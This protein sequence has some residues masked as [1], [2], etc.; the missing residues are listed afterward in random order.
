MEFKVF[1]SKILPKYIN[2][3]KI[4]QKYIRNT[5]LIVLIYFCH[6]FNWFWKEIPQIHQK[7][8]TNI[9]LLPHCQFCLQA[10]NTDIHVKL[11][12]VGEQKLYSWTSLKMTNN[13]GTQTHEINDSGGNSK[14]WIL[15]L[16]G[17]KWK[18]HE[19]KCSIWDINIL[20]SIFRQFAL[21]D[22]VNYGSVFSISLTPIDRTLLS[23]RSIC[24]SKE[25]NLGVRE[26]VEPFFIC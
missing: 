10:I 4:W 5:F 12:L 21:I 13:F 8:P 24:F 25:R 3:M 6:I 18:Q 14:K 20:A 16:L 11:G 9:C 1:P 19:L 2:T 7:Q 15:I 23:H 26:S 22:S 17:E